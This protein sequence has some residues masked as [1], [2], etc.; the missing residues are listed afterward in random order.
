[1]EPINFQ[2]LTPAQILCC[3]CGII[4]EPNPTNT[5]IACLRRNHDFTENIP[6]ESIVHFCKKCER[7]KIEDLG[8]WVA[9][10]LE[11]KE[12]MF[13]LLKKIKNSIQHLKLIDVDFVWTE[14]HSRRIKI[15][16]YLQ[17]EIVGG[18]ILQRDVVIEFVVHPLMCDDCHRRE[19]K[20]YWK[21]VVQVRQ[22]VSHKKTLYFLE[23]LLLKFQAHSKCIDIKPMHDGID[24]FFLK[25]D[26]AEKLSSFL[27]STVASR[28]TKSKQLITH[29]V[30]NNTYNYKYTFSVEIVPI[31]KDDVVCLP[32]SLA[33]SLGNIGPICVVLRVTNL[34][35]LIDPFTLKVAELNA[36]SY[37][38][39][40][41]RS[42]C[43]SNQLTEFTV[44]DLD[45]IT[46]DCTNS[47]KKQCSSARK[48]TK[49]SLADVYLVKSSEIG[50][51][52]QTHTRSH[53]GG[54]LNPGDLVL[55]FDLSTANINEPNWER[56]ER[57]HQDKIPDII[58]VKKCYGD[59]ASRKRRRRW[60]LKRM[61]P[62]TGSRSNIIGDEQDDDYEQFMEDLEEDQTMRQF[63]EVYKDPKKIQSNHEEENEEID[64]PIIT[65]QEMIDDLNIDDDDN[66]NG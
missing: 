22:K 18:A 59:R 29:D 60:R 23:Q 41:F 54:I 21:A 46:N 19:A 30:H 10:E 4:I 16:V 28:L 58:L 12:L 33:A 48:A 2:Q 55:G 49:Y 15:K 36:T 6:R 13:L 50:T 39:S 57:S 9:C 56:Y 20:N 66:M 47:S 61:D 62:R 63:V 44:M 32:P 42:I 31:C 52:D 7:Y 26:D 24:F 27:E 38:R 5:C 51:A 45:K 1:M 11:S 53:L 14:P 43:Y 65:L 34:I 3:D 17:K 40:P 25:R 37:F 64:E 8:K 35:S